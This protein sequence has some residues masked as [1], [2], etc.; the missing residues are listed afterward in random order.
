MRAWVVSRA[1]RALKVSQVS[2]DYV[3][4]TRPNRRTMLPRIAI[5]TP[6]SRPWTTKQAIANTYAAGSLSVD[7]SAWNR[8]QC[9]QAW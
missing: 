6:W 9:S 2:G 5:L 1:R 7:L 4:E 8:D 3:G